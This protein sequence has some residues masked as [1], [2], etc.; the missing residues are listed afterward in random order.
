MLLDVSAEY[1]RMMGERLRRRKHDQAGAAKVKADFQIRRDDIRLPFG[2]FSIPG[3]LP[4]PAY[5][6]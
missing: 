2:V 1:T 3:N 6:M 4:Q 5:V